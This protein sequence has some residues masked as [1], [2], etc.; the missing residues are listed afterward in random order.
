MGLLRKFQQYRR[1][2]QV[3]EVLKICKISESLKKVKLLEEN[4]IHNEQFK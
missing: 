1:I 2:P 3:T 4:T